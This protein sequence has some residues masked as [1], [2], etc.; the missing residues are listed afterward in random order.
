M[1][2]SAIEIE[3]PADF[4]S[5]PSLKKILSDNRLSASDNNVVFG[6]FRDDL[7][8]DGYAIAK[9]A[10]PRDRADAYGRVFYDF[11]ESL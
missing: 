3:S 4:S 8:R 1:A 6:D 11:L 9:G 7:I 2:P 5:T 10:V